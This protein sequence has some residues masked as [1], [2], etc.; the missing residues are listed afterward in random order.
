MEKFMKYLFLQGK[1]SVRSFPAI[2][3]ATFLLTAGMCV[4]VMALFHMDSSDDSKQKVQIGVVGDVTD[5]YLE[6]GLYALENMDD[7]RYT[8]D[9]YTMTE[10]EARKKLENGELTAYIRIPEGFVESVMVA[11]NKTITYVTSSGGVNFGSIIMQELVEV[12]SN[13]LVESQNGI[14]GMQEFAKRYGIEDDAFW[15]VTMDMNKRYVDYILYRGNLYDIEEIGVADQLS[16]TG[17][18]VCG[19]VLL[20]F[21]LWGINGS[22]LLIKKDFALSKLLA[23]KGLK[24]A[25]QALGEFLAY[26]G[27]MVVSLMSMVSILL[28]AIQKYGVVIPEWSDDG[29]GSITAF[30]VGLLLVLFMVGAMQFLLYELTSGLVSGVLLQ[31]LSA[32]TLGYLSG[33]LY[34]I[35]FFPESIQRL[36]D[37]LPTGIAI[38]YMNHMM[39]AEPSFSEMIGMM[40]YSIIFLLLVIFI[41]QRRMVREG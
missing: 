36:A 25:S 34:P 14:Y 26:I 35:D 9:F 30:L 41:R 32:I 39:L 19:I 40:L 23:S 33:C 8:V 13:L 31:F 28:F 15:D 21:L 5:T 17:Y 20:L 3:G 38:R 22:T 2:F 29:E 11:E 4:L 10:K 27:L 24:A 7:T 12:V 6:W 1:R 18:Y 16:M 37:I